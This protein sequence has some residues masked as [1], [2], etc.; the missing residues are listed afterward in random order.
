MLNRLLTLISGDCAPILVESIIFVFLKI[1]DMFET[2]IDLL[3][4][5]ECVIVPEF[6]G[7]VVNDCAAK[8][9]DGKFFPPRKELVYN[10]KLVHNDGD[11][12]TALSAAKSCSFEEANRMISEEVASM[13]KALREDGIFV[14]PNFGVFTM[15]SGKV[16]FLQKNLKIA[17]GDSFGL[18]EFYFPA[19]DKSQRKGNSTTEHSASKVLKPLTVAAVAVVALFFTVQPINDAP[20]TDMAS[21]VPQINSKNS[22]QRELDVKNK[23]LSQVQSEL[24]A[25]RDAVDGYYLIVADFPDEESAASYLH[26]AKNKS[27]KMLGIDQHFY[28]SAFSAKTK[29]EV[30]A[31][32]DQSE[33]L[34][35]TAYV[36][37]VSKFKNIQNDES[38]DT[39]L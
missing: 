10:S 17:C 29:E 30:V 8:V 32:R 16:A 7:F 20:Q 37:S 26:A 4:R 31:F 24:D 6:G 12:A 27:L 18:N 22:L 33:G 35:E 1:R 25:Y 34:A 11:L 19:L 9:V 21:M 15:K 38:N 28:I 13:W 36:L 23:E 3:S 14:A 5:R 2:I 39:G